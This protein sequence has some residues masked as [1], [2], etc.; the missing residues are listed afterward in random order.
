MVTVATLIPVTVHIAF[1][2]EL[3]ELMLKAPAL[4]IPPPVVHVHAYV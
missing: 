3:S 4:V 2:A 1:T